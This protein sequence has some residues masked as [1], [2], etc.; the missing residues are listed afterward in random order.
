LLFPAVW[1]TSV[2]TVFVVALGRRLCLSSIVGVKGMGPKTTK[3]VGLLDSASSILHS[4]GEDQWSAWLQ[5]DAA[6]L[7]AG[8]LKGIVHFLSAFGGMG[9]IYDLVLHP[10][11]GHRVADSDLSNVNESLHVLLSEAW[12]LAREIRNEAVIQ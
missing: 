8:D 3:L 2:P 12:E 6:L 7:R 11:N 9:S 1:A 5:K 10:I 4:C